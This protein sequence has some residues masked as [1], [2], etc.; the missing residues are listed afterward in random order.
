MQADRGGPL[1]HTTVEM[2]VWRTLSNR[3]ATDLKSLEHHTVVRGY[4]PSV[5]ELFRLL[6][7]MSGTVYTAARHIRAVTASLLQPP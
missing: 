5:T 6:W 4:Q 1:C 7:L 3:A 2:T